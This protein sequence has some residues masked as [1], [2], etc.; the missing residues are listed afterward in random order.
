MHRAEDER[1]DGVMFLLTAIIIVV[2]SPLEGRVH[3]ALTL[4]VFVTAVVFTTVVC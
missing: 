2:F 4:A 1:G 3:D